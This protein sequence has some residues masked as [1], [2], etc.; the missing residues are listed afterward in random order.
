VRSPEAGAA[1]FDRGSSGRALAEPRAVPV[2]AARGR[3]FRTIWIRAVSAP[4]T[5]L[6]KR[7]SP[8]DLPKRISFPHSKPCE[9]RGALRLR[10]CA[11]FEDRLELL[12]VV[13]QHY[14]VGNFPDVVR[15]VKDPAR[16]AELCGALNIPHPKISMEMPS[17]HH[18]WLVKSAGGAGG[19]HVAPAG[20]SRGGRENL[21]PRL[22]AGRACFD[23]LCCRWHKGAVVG[24]S[25]NGRRGAGEPF[26]FA[27][28][29]ARPVYR[30]SCRRLRRVA[31]EITA[32]AGFAVSTASIFLSKAR[33]YDDRN[34]PRQVRPSIFSM[35]AAARFFRAHVESCRGRLPLLPLAFGGAAAAE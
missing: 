1:I 14:A 32:A 27:A 17:D 4:R 20:Q 28:A 22:A 31:K 9:R 7:A 12:E 25:V 26:R 24:L 34:H 29:F 30:A 8:E 18:Q 3:L 13:A 19:S 21:L 16:L 15:N 5:I 11:G 33:L 6:S 2:P 35:I 10:L 23:P